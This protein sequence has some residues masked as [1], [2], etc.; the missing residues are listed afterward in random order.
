MPN[1]ESNKLAIVKNL[2]HEWK[3]EE[4]LRQINDIE[5]KENLTLEEI[6]STQFYKGRLRQLLGQLEISLKIAE[7]FIGF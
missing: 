5:Q 4:A 7:I 6:L 1:S 3:Y 2:I